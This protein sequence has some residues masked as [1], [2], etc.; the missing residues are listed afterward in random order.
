[1]GALNDI[2]DAVDNAMNVRDQRNKRLKAK[3]LAKKR[4]DSK[5]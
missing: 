2:Y 1:M 3:T 5:K 4:L